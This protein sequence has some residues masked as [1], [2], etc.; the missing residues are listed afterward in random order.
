MK[1]RAIE[2]KDI[3]LG[4][5]IYVEQD[6]SFDT[7]PHV[8]RS[9]FDLVLNKINLTVVDNKIAQIWGYCPYSS[10]K[11]TNTEVPKSKPGVLQV[12]N[13]FNKG[14]SY[15][16]SEIELSTYVNQISGWVC[17]GDLNTTSN[18]IQIMSNC[19]AVLNFKNE[20][21]AIWLRPRWIKN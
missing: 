21:S 8:G 14:F 11:T 18:A 9:D 1:F 13:D 19:V 20:L 7:I 3:I 6:Y 5:V 16:I 15:G 2:E 17:I 4:E 10:W 12:C